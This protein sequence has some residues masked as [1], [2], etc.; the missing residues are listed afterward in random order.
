MTRTHSA[1]ETSRMKR[2]VE[3][4]GLSGW[5][6]GGRVYGLPAALQAAQ[7]VA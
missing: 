1:R 5:S 7:E 4:E 6:G 2:I 3:G